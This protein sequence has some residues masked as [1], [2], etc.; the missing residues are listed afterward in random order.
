MRRCLLISFIFLFAYSGKI[1]AQ[2]TTLGQN[3]STAFPVCGTTTFQQLNV[4]ICSSNNLFVPGCVSTPAT[5]YEN[6]NPFWYKFTCYQS[7]TLGFTI[8][9]NVATDDYDWQLYDITGHNPDDVYTINS[10]VVT[11]NWS[12]TYGNTGASSNGL[13]FIQCASDPAANE[14]TF[15]RMPN[16]YLGHQ[17]LLLISHYTD[18]QSGYGL[19][20]GNGT[21]SITDPLLPKMD[22]AVAPCD[23]SVIIVNLNKKMKC[24]SIST[25]EFFIEPPIAT[26]T[27]VTGNGCS[28]S[29]DLDQLTLTLSTPLPPGSYKV[30]IK[31][32]SDGNTLLDNCDRP[33]PENDSLPLTVFPVF[34]TPMDSITKPG[35][36]PQSLEL[37][38]KKRIRCGSVAPDGSDFLVTGPYP[39][40]VTA[41]SGNCTDGLSYNIMVQLSAPMLVAGNFHISLVQGSDHNTLI[42]ECG[43]QS[44]DTT[45]NFSVKDTVNA[46]FSSVIRLGCSLDTVKY[47]HNGAN[48][49]NN[50]VWNFDDGLYTSTLQNPVVLYNTFGTHQTQLIVSNGVCSDTAS[51]SIYLRNTLKAKFDATLLVCPE[52]PASFKDLSIEASPG[53][54]LVS[55][56]WDFA[57]GNT[58]IL[59]NPPNQFYTY[60]SADYYAPV[61]LVVTDFLGCKDT[62]VLNLNIL[63]NCYIA[64]PSAFTPNGDG[65]NDYLYPLNAYKATNL[66]FSIFNRFG[67]RI[68]YTTDWSNKW[69][70]RF[71]GQGADPGTYV[72]MLGYFDTKK[73]RQIFE[74]GT[75]VL[76]R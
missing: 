13:N 37:V 36:S 49:V 62:A 22:S 7:G 40:T 72:W 3:P 20:F 1:K 21:A 48:T 56:Q 42:D 11:G 18:T 55:W 28:S 4:P 69:D 14:N 43:Q 47:F 50:W 75:V 24:S 12:G 58:S 52:D 63:H 33:I 59:Q 45:I 6:K 30:K 61:K 44:H 17:Y 8:V 23:G 2:C 74:K 46:N 65:L 26:V 16:I 25:G 39:V 27:S 70:G 73:N 57:N 53:N 29:F 32:G 9:P 41:A 31:N 64:V 19:S 15:A 68:F 67:Q 5:N 71:K 54:S 38:F 66:K 35:C 51:Q 76:I 10:L 34:P 60:H